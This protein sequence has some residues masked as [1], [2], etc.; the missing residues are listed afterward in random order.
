[1]LT[2]PLNL[3]LGVLDVRYLTLGLNHQ[4]NGQTSTLSR[5]WNRIYAEVGRRKASSA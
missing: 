3:P 4:S 1:M 5:S 2:T